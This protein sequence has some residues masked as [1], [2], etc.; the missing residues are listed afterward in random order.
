MMKEREKI[1]LVCPYDIFT[2]G[3]VKE[4]VFGLG[5]KLEKWGHSV[6]IFAPR[7]QKKEVP[8]VIFF[9]QA[10]SI[11]TPTWS[12]GWVTGQINEAR[13]ERILQQ[14]KF[15]I[16]HVHAPTVPKLGQTILAVSRKLEL[17]TIHIAT[18][19]AVLP[20]GR[21]INYL[22]RLA[23]SYFRVEEVEAG[24]DGII[25]VSKVAKE[26]WRPY[27]KKEITVIANGLDLTR[28][29]PE[30]RP[31]EKYGDGKINILF[32][33]RFEP[34]KGAI[35]LLRAFD[36]MK[37]NDA[38]LIFVGDGPSRMIL[39]TYILAHDLKNVKLVGRVSEKDLPRWYATADICCFP[40]T[41]F[42]SFGYVVV[43]AMAVGKPVVVLANPGYLGVLEGYPFSEGLVPVDDHKE[44]GLAQGLTILLD[45]E[46]KRKML[47]KWGRKKV[48]QYAWPRVAREI[49]AYYRATKKRLISEGK[50]SG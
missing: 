34:R 4:H 14:E 39:E 5:E 3:G 16:I 44:E 37:R 7:T 42:E 20:Q 33:G 27:L 12:W 30:V 1:A 9:G 28:F 29:H 15:D 18:L 22:R 38:R 41:G 40:S 31:F 23:R 21:L 2:P 47:G 48:E 32:V 25:A 24:L 10:I 11:P 13:V 8:G 6:L 46:N 43:Q 45:D 26:C 19:H 36:Q 35:H 49:L 50:I 17:G